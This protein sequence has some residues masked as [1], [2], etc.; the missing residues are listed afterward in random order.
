MVECCSIFLKLNEQLTG[1]VS[2]GARCRSGEEQRDQRVHPVAI[3]PQYACFVV[4]A[5]TE[6]APRSLPPSSGAMF[7]ADRY[8][9][10]MKYTSPAQKDLYPRR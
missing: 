9:A 8:P 1:R 4:T 10:H 2:D 6:N 3:R 5:R 7:R